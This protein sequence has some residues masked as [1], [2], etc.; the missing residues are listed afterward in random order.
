MKRVF[1]VMLVAFMA[2]G[3]VFAADI[4]DYIPTISVSG[5]AEVTMQPD[6][7]SFQISASSVEATTDEARI[8]TSEMINTA[9]SILMNS[10][11]I[12]EDDLATSYISAS[13]EYQWIDDEKVLV[14]QRATQT[15]DVKTKN[16][17]SIGSI[18]EELMKIDGITVSDVTLDKKDKSEEY[19][20]ARMEAV[21][22]AYAKAE[23][24]LE[25]A[26]AKVGRIL[27]ITD[28]S[29]YATPIYRTA[30]LMLAS[31]DTAAKE[32]STEYYTDDISVSA[33]VSIVYEIVQ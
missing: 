29:S 9:V 28:G 19:R 16:L 3:A 26:G 27:S 8:K 21:K 24:Y 33:S 7:A 23:A 10:F 12:T 13:P 2:L 6:T 11:G 4:P 25:A 30:N 1:A 14:G 31:A 5:R 32:V 20:E 22:D 17:D 18:Y 15:V